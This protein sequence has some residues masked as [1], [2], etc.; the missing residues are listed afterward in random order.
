V[1][2]AGKEPETAW[3]TF[4]KRIIVAVVPQVSDRYSYIRKTDNVFAHH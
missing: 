1:G 2:S 3:Q 4:S